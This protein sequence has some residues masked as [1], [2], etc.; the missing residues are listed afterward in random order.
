MHLTSAPLVSVCIPTYNRAEKL[1][2]AV[3]HLLA[4]THSNLE[5]VISDNASTDATQKICLDLCSENENIRYFRHAINLGPTRNFEFARAQATGK[6]FL[7]H[8]DD[9]YLD[10]NFIR[11]CVDALEKDSSLILVSGLSAFHRGDDVITHHGNHIELE[12]RAGW[13]R[14]LKFIFMVEDGSIFCGLYRRADVAE[15]QAPNCLGGDHVWLVEVLFKGKARVIPGSLIYRE[16]GGSTSSSF[17]RLVATLGLP[18]WHA[19]YPWIAL[20][21]NLANH[22]AFSSSR[23][24]YKWLPAKLGAWL[25]IFCTAL[26]KQAI[27]IVTPA[28]PF[29]PRLY[30]WFFLDRR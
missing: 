21:L 13:L 1:S 5:I 19:R 25:V 22:L 30:R 24:P 26:S 16:F 29:G 10:A 17:E 28:L 23:Y 3:R 27:L 20:P 9:D 4:Q 6:Y 18:R 14:A 8:G 7:W 12:S 15:C 2:R 11:V